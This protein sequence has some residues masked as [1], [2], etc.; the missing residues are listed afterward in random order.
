MKYIKLFEELDYDEVS[1]DVFLADL[2]DI[3]MFSVK[4]VKQPKDYGDY[5]ISIKIESLLND[6]K[7]DLLYDHSK[8][9]ADEI[10]NLCIVYDDRNRFGSG[11]GINNK[12]N[13]FLDIF[14]ALYQ[15]DNKSIS[16]I[17]DKHPQYVDILRNN[18]LLS[19]DFFKDY[20]YLKNELF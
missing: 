3:L 20:A 13:L 1:E 2:K 8:W 15:D 18:G 14:Q 6:T 10:A 7:C 4:L 11:E 16:K 17:L 5:D 9:C 12:T 19:D